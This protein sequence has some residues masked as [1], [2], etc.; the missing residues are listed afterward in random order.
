[1]FYNLK[2]RRYLKKLV[3]MTVFEKLLFNYQLHFLFPL[4]VNLQ[5][6]KVFFYTHCPRQLYIFFLRANNAG[7]A[8]TLIDWTRLFF[9]T[10]FPSIMI[11]SSRFLTDCMS[12][13]SDFCPRAPAPQGKTC[14]VLRIIKYLQCYKCTF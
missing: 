5:Y 11:N 9:P 8:F 6:T 7:F 1:M 4:F 10:S 3:F 13:N 12:Q 14:N 2:T